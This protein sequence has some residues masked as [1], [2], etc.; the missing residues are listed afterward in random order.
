MPDLSALHGPLDEGQTPL[1]PDEAAGLRLSWVTTRAD[2]N[3]VEA[4]NIVQGITWARRRIATG[5][6]V[7]PSEEFLRALHARM[8]GQVWAWAGQFRSSER[9]IGVAP[10][11]IAMQLRLLF[12]DVEAWQTYRSYPLDEQAARLHHRLT[13]IHPFANGNGRCSRVMADLF[14]QRHRAPVFSWG[15]APHG[16]A[17][18]N[19]YLAAIRQA[20]TGDFTALLAFVRS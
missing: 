7:I 18:R 19:Q 4:A 12:D 6:A 11:Q 1:D 8:F 14:L 3:D 15:S 20:D 5:T 2:L 10:H 16:V 9:N 17:V 13:F